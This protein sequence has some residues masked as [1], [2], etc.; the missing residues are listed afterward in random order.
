MGG[1]LKPSRRIICCPKTMSSKRKSDASAPS[2]DKRRHVDCSTVQLSLRTF[3]KSTA[4]DGNIVSNDG[5]GSSSD[6]KSTTAGDSQKSE[7]AS[8]SRDTITV[9]TPEYFGIHM[10]DVADIAS[11]NGLEKDYRMR[12]H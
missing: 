8:T 7:L 11:V 9:I 10:Y 2:A 12:R 5:E 1:G 6:I 3:F 4:K